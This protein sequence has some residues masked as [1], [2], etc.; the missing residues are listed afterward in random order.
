MAWLHCQALQTLAN[1][2]AAE[3]AEGGGHPAPSARNAVSRMV[4]LSLVDTR[5]LGY[6]TMESA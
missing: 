3:G 6:I 1:P 5:E 4:T 2:T